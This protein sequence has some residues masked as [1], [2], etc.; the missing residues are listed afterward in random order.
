M[1]K[2]ISPDTLILL[3]GNFSVFLFSGLDV[4]LPDQAMV[5]I[6][7]HVSSWM[8]IGWEH[9]GRKHAISMIGTVPTASFKVMCADGRFV[10]VGPAHAMTP[11]IKKLAEVVRDLGGPLGDVFQLL[12]ATIE[13]LAHSEMTDVLMQFLDLTA[14]HSGF[15]EVAALPETGGLF[16]QGWSNP[17]IAQDYRLLTGTGEVSA[18]CAGFARDD[19]IAPAA[20]FCLYARNHPG[21]FRKTKSVFLWRQDDLRRLDILPELSEP[22]RGEA[23]NEHIRAMIPRLAAKAP[24]VSKF[25]RICRPRFRGVDTLSN[26]DGPVAVGLDMVLQ[27]EGGLFVTGWILD[28]LAQID[29]ALVKSTADLYAPLRPNAHSLHRPDLLDAFAHAPRFAGLLDPS[30][31][32][33][34][35]M[36]FVPATNDQLSGAA[37]YLELVL[38]DGQ[39]LFQPITA[40]QCRDVGAAHAVLNTVPRHDPAVKTILTRHVAPFLVGLCAKV[41]ESQHQLIP[42]GEDIDEGEKPVAALM[43]M[44]RPE[45]LKPVFASLSNTPEAKDIHLVI[46][47]DDTVDP[48]VVTDLDNQFRFYGLSGG[49]V[50]CPSKMS[51]AARLD[52]ALGMT[53]APHILLWGPQALPQ[54]RGWLDLLRSEAA[55]LPTPGLVSPM[56][57]YEDGSI[58]FG[59]ERMKGCPAQ[60]ISQ[61]AGFN[62]I[63]RDDVKNVEVSAGAGELALIDRDLLVA[64]GGIAGRLLGDKYTHHGLGARLRRNNAAAWCIPR[65]EFWMLPD[66]NTPDRIASSSFID[67]VDA[68][69]IAHLSPLQN[70]GAT[71]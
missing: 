19:L 43:T 29:L 11:D 37:L 71:Q 20:G 64:V 33:N 2:I 62:R 35:F 32:R 65:V 36:C 60:A 22:V 46:I 54:T 50:S 26:Y 51:K 14:E 42:V 70:A 3:P 39:C 12:R 47:I 8:N 56:L 69:I 7:P 31:T 4:E 45:D 17:T 6:G 1:T 9:S 30:E 15:V 25:K 38:H 23:A 59:G 66:Q 44:S 18:A 63:N 57:S 67:D 13:E 61:L 5:E 27:A 16:L 52:L 34:G 53:N 21:E 58:H 49:V 28:P 48:Q 40:R 24:V 55:A 10:E 41:A 68:A